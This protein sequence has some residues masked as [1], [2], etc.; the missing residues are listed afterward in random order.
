[1]EEGLR[2]SSGGELSGM[3]REMEHSDLSLLFLASC[4]GL[5]LAEATQKPE[6][7]G[8]HSVVPTGPP[9]GQAAERGRAQRTL[10][11]ALYLRLPMGK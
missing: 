5:L 10:D 9:P 3:G 8:A 2:Q 4:W 6:G 1:M 11:Y 7:K